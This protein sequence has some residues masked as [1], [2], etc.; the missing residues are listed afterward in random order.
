MSKFLWGGATSSAQYEGGFDGIKG[1]DTQDCRKYLPRTNNATTA[2]RLLTKSSVEEAKNLKSDNYYPFRKG[3]DG[4]HHLE[5]DLKLIKELGLEI[6]RFSISWS[7]LF[8]QGDESKP[9][10]IGVAYYDKIFRFLKENNIKI[11]L[12]VTHYA[13]PLY[14]VEHYGGWK[15]KKMIDFYLNYISFIFDRWGSYVDY[16]LPFNEINTGFFSPF[17]GVGLIREDEITP[18][19]Y[20]DIFQSL[21]NQFVANARSIKLAREKGLCGKFGAMVACFCY[22]PMS[23]KPEE[24]LKLVKEEQINQWFATDVLVNGSYPYYMKSFFKKHNVNLDFSEEEKHLLADYP[25]DFMSFSYYSSSVISIDEVEKT[26]GNLVVTTKNPYLK[27]SDW[28]W[29][30]DPV[31]LRTTLNKAYDRYKKPI[32]ISENGFGAKDILTSDYKVHDDYRIEYFKSHF[33]E[34]IKARD[35][36]DVDVIAYIAWGIIDIVSAGSCEMDKR[37]GVVYVDADNYGQGTY[38]RYKKDSFEWYKAFIVSQN[39]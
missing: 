8:P 31:G 22:Y 6:Y 11:F 9:N 33:D 15:N 26:A 30:I 13:I 37:Y 28:G 35:L 19:K 27:S 38:R 24:N 7:R 5:E 14:L 29:Q 12:S 23:A 20:Q 1:M 32:I 18:Y 21:H 17:N 39:N 16:W 10:E 3:T 25:C 34:I 2:T 4:Y 36:D